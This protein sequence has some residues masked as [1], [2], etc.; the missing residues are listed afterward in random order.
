MAVIGEVNVHS[1]PYICC[2]KIVVSQN[3]LIVQ[4]YVYDI[5]VYKMLDFLTGF[6]LI[7]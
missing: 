2:T 3:W 1:I 6:C 5:V 7:R 4:T